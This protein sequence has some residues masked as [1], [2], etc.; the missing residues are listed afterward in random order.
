MKS[1]K[2]FKNICGQVLAAKKLRPK[3]WIAAFDA[4][5]TLWDTDLGE[6]FFDYEI[7]HSRL[8]LPSDPWLHYLTTKK[9]DTPKAYLWLAQI[10]AGVPLSTVRDWAEKAYTGLNPFPIFDFQ[11]RLIQFLL[12]E[13]FEI[14]IVTASVKWA[15]EPGARRLGVPIENVLGITTAT[16]SGLVTALQEGPITWREGKATALLARTAQVHPILCAGNTT[17]DT[18]LLE[19]ASDV[20]LAVLSQQPGEHLYATEMELQKIATERSW[21]RVDLSHEY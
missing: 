18:A 20:R 11:K 16:E 8:S 2:Q 17:G 1:E 6:L 14:Y 9:T 13:E 10:N 3:P 12:Q 5:G 21:T 15:V 4:D 7:R 19:T